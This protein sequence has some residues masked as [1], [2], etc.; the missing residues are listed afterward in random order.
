[1]HKFFVA[2]EQIEDSQIRV[3]GA[4]CNHILRVL[5]LK[6][7]QEIIL[8]DG[9]GTDYYC[10]IKEGRETEIICQISDIHR[11]YTELPAEITLFQG[12]PKQEK[13]EWIIQKSVELGVSQIYPVA[14][15]R[16]VQ[17]L[18]EKTAAKKVERWN[19]IAE[20]AAKQS[21]RGKV[22]VVQMPVSFKQVM[23]M[24][25]QY[26]MF[27]APHEDATGISAT[28]QALDSIEKS[29]KIA[30]MIG[31]EGGYSA[32]ETADLKTLT[33]VRMITLGK[34]ILRTETAAAAFL[35]MVTIMIEEDA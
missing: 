31:P 14:M 9:Q 26:Q 22:P 3:V 35:S 20:S 19:K 6:P 13:M 30:C 8:N 4:D 23:A 7:G 32:E 27:F 12:L 5:R 33:N 17:K 10:I 16:S 1:M 28:R 29:S 2:R 34:R 21:G 25:G 11:S 18:D 15:K 24:A